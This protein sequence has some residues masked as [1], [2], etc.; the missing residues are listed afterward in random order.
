MTARPLRRAGVVLATTLA[1]VAPLAFLAAPA[2]AAAPP[3][4]FSC[5]GGLGEATTVRLVSGL[6]T[7]AGIP[8]Q[9]IVALPGPGAIV[10]SRTGKAAL[11]GPSWLH[12][13]YTE[14]DV[15]GH[16][17]NGDLYHLNLPPVLPG[18][19]GFVDADLDIEFAGGANGSWQIPMFDCTVTGGPARLSTPSGPRTFSCT[20]GL[21]E[22]FTVR[23]VTGQLTR[24]NR[25]LQVSVAQTETG[26]VESTRAKQA[27]LIGPSW[28]HAGYTEWDVTGHNPNGDL[29]HLNVPPVLPPVGGYFD[30]DLDIE[31]AGGTNGSWQI[32]M[33]DCTVA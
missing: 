28:L 15:T 9:V 22:A 30:A 32:P 14:W 19:G 20:G 16:A 27:A 1:V 13:G 8:Y 4:A 31:F 2:Q 25:P 7:S 12:S 29:F 10:S 17:Q 18:A 3:R 26:V 33:F 5:S 6:L 23:T 21:G 24:L 11:V